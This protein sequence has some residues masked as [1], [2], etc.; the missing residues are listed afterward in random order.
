[1]LVGTP[2]GNFLR[3]FAGQTNHDA[4]VNQFVR[5]FTP[6]E[7]RAVE[8]TVSREPAPAPFL[9]IVIRTKGMRPRQ[10]QDT[11]LSLAGQSSQDFTILIVRHLNAVADAAKIQ[12]IAT[13]FPDSL[14]SR[15]KIMDCVGNGRAAPL[16]IALE[17]LESRY[18]AF[19]DDDDF[20]FGHYVETFQNIAQSH[21]GKLARATCARQQN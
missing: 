3:T 4:L 14:S 7:R 10:L 9:T 2:L 6:D 13:S 5:A 19:L 1:M 16:N 12:D 17:H 11:L 20:V 8:L 21:P 18:V 15:I